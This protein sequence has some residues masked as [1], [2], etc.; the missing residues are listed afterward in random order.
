MIDGVNKGIETRTGLP[1]KTWSIELEPRK[2]H[3][4]TAMIRYA[5]RS[6]RCDFEIGVDDRSAGFRRS[7]EDWG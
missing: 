6:F 2:S 7:D 1:L 3:S 4:V 5:V